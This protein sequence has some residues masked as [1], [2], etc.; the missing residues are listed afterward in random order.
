MA[1]VE[2]EFPDPDENE[3]IEIE[4]SSEIELNQGRQEVTPELGDPVE[5]E[6]EIE[7]VDDTPEADRNRKASKPPEEVTDEELEGYSDKVRNRIKH[8]TKGYNDERRAKEAALRE[9]DELEQMTQRLLDE[10]NGLKHDVTRNQSQ[11]VKQA[12]TTTELELADAKVEY[13]RAY[14]AG[15]PDG[16]LDAQEKLTNAKLKADKLAEFEANTLQ[17]QEIDVQQDNYAPQQVR[18]PD[19]QAAAW[20]KENA[21]FQ[22]PDH[23]DMTAFATGLHTKLVRQGINPTSPNYYQRINTRM[24]EV[25]PDY[26]GEPEKKRSNSVVAPATRSTS[27][28]KVR[29]SQT[30][31]NLAKRLGIT[32]EQYA[33]QVAIEMRKDKNGR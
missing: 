5:D 15:D 2:F 18:E 21:W 23:S 19:A 12:Q 27:P 9:R 7:V 1:R 11:L 26:F 31:V 20:H 10:N 25:F 33:K 29:L 30:Q 13:K 22:D 3:E 16:L 17:Q 8:F 32:P 24:R 28:K 4:P 6:I 14:E